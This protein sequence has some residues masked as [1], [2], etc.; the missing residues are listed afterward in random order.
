M[1]IIM[2]DIVLPD[3]EIRD[4]CPRREKD[5]NT[6]SVTGCIDSTLTP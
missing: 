4:L 6:I 5:Y 3:P 1:I 2:H